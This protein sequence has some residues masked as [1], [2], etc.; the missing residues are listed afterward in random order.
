MKKALWLLALA[1]ALAT[2]LI[3]AGCG[4]DDDDGGDGGEALTKQEFIT[5]ADQ[6]CS[7]GNAEIEA[8]AEQTFGQSDQP[9]SA[10]EQEQFAADTVIPN[11]QSQV[12]QIGDLAPPEGDED[13]IQAILDAARE[14]LDAGEEEP[15]LFTE[16]GGQDPLAEASRLARDYG[17][18]VCGEE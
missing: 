16:Q 9:P 14:G 6:I 4:D 8:A 18:T 17:L 11:I 13:Q 1:L 10:T 3:A 5:E 12:D 15:S 7:D 2:G